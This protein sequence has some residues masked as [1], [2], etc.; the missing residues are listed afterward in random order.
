MFVTDAKSGKRT[1]LQFAPFHLHCLLTYKTHRLKTPDNT[2][3]TLDELRE[4]RDE[5]N[6]TIDVLEQ[7]HNNLAAKAA[8]AEKEGF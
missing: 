7:R 8:E 2:E 1:F 3:V 6:Q 5:M 4:W